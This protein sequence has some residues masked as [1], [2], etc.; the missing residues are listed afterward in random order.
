MN[1]TGFH[2]LLRFEVGLENMSTPPPQL[3]DLYVNKCKLNRWPVGISK[4][5]LSHSKA[6]LRVIFE[7][8]KGHV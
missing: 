5:F 8:K 7:F 6:Y 1:S 2:V 4:L 3:F